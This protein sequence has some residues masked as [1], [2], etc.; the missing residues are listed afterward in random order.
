MAERPAA[1]RAPLRGDLLRRLLLLPR[2]ALVAEPLLAGAVALPLVTAATVVP[3]RRSVLPRLR[4]RLVGLRLV[5]LRRSGGRRGRP[6]VRLVGRRL[7]LRR[8]RLELERD[9]RARHLRRRRGVVQSRP[10]GQL[11]DHGHERPVVEADR[12]HVAVS[13][14]R[15]GRNR[16]RDGRQQQQYGQKPWNL[17][18]GHAQ[19]FRLHLSMNSPAMRG[20]RA[21]GSKGV[22]ASERRRSSA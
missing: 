1:P 2:V 12:D 3:L 9:R 15:R 16:R 5:R 21:N 17:G 20:H 10:R 13:G 8:R 19:L 18:P 14:G 22:H 7:D 11:G 4:A 6:R